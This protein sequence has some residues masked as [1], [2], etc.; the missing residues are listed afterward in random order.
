MKNTKTPYWPRLSHWYRNERTGS[1]S[2][3]EPWSKTTHR[4]AKPRSASSHASRAPLLTRAAGSPWGLAVSDMV[5]GRLLDMPTESLTD[6]VSPASPA[7]WL[8][9]EEQRAWRAYIRLA[10]LLMRRLRSEERRVGKECRSRWS[11]Y[12]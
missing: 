9:E 1:S 3:V 4:A 10:Q 8:S 5:L 12:H 11:P 2:R 6:G 7:R